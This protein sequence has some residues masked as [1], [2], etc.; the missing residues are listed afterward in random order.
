MRQ[1]LKLSGGAGGPF[2][3][4]SFKSPSE[5]ALVSA[6]CVIHTL[7][8]RI[9]P[10]SSCTAELERRGAGYVISGWYL[11]PMRKAR[12]LVFYLPMHGG[13]RRGAGRKPRGAKALV[14][15]M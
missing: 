3:T 8:E 4:S 15:H 5:P 10:Q 7:V 13:K 12:Q 9:S 1:Q 6:P 2:S 11:L 14:G